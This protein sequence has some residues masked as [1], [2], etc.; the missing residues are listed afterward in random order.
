MEFDTREMDQFDRDLLKFVRDTL[1]TKSK[2]FMNKEGRTLA[3]KT[4][5]L[6]K[7][8]VKKKTGSY[9]KSLKKTKAWQNKS[10]GFGVKVISKRPPGYHSHLL[11]YGHRV[12]YYG[13]D[14][15]HKSQAFHIQGDALDDYQPTFYAN[16]VKFAY[17]M[18]ENGFE[19]R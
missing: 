5:Q 9:F 15:G 19:G 17:E 1:P 11:E 14:T 6:A 8:R 10:G 13:H 7:S 2:Q 3:S 4:K 16:A 18:M 12:F